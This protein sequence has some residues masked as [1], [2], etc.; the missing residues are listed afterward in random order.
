MKI[1]KRVRRGYALALAIL[2]TLP[3]LSMMRIQAATA[4]EVDRTCSLTV[5]AADS[6]YAEDFDEMTI[7]VSLYRVASVDTVGRYTPEAPFSGMD[8]SDIGSGTTADDWQKLALQA[9]E[10]IK[11]LPQGE[12]PATATTEVKKSAGEETATGKFTD[13]KTGMY[14]V[15]PE[16]SVNEEQTVRYSFTPYLTALPSSEY[17]AAG[18]GSDDWD[19]EP[20]I[21]LK[22]EGEE[23]TGSLVIRKTLSNYNVSLGAMTCVFQVEGHDG[24]GRLAYSNVIS[25]TLAGAGDA[26]A[27]TAKLTGI[28][29][30]LEVTVTE[31]YAGGSYEVQGDAVQTAVILSDERVGD[32][33][34]A[35]VSF[36]NN[37][38]GG[39]RGG[40]GV[41]N[42]FESDGNNG[43]KW[44][45]PTPPAVE[46]NE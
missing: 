45:N 14:L 16:A 28:P 8:F 13:L 31:I 36:T 34:P 4:I 26:N 11:G 18:A 42:H 37:Y 33:E 17:A 29:A 15:V 22:A 20:V 40:Y 25:L 44:E 38:D 1:S 10:C 12:V 19:Y 2:L 30:G 41:T 6:G 43:W 35:T 5:S 24:D 27:Q 39:N 21:G 46:E 7:P 23:L 32:G 9:E 3:C